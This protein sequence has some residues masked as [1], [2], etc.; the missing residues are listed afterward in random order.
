MPNWTLYKM[1]FL[2]FQIVL[3]WPTKNRIQFFFPKEMSTKY[4]SRYLRTEYIV[5]NYIQTTSVPN[6]KQIYSCLAVQWPKNQVNVTTSLFEPQFL[7]FL[8]VACPNKWHF[9]N[10]QTKLDNIGIFWKDFLRSEIWPFFTWTWPDIGSVKWVS[11]TNA[12]FQM[13]LKACVTR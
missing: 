4:F 8:I 11:Q 13:T 3:F 10:P 6:F 12:T 7:A 1:V 2:H 9:W 5:L